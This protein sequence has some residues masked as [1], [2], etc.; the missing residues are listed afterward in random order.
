MTKIE[1]LL[2]G[3]EILCR[4]SKDLEFDAQHDMIYFGYEWI[5]ELV[6]QE[7]RNTLNTL[8]FFEIEDYQCFGFFT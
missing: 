5:V 7:D 6:S 3:I 1:K 4:Y 8:G 2:K